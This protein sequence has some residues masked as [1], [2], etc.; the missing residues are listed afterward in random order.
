M[1]KI[2]KENSVN[3]FKFLQPDGSLSHSE[4][5]YIELFG[6]MYNQIGLQ[7]F[8]HT[9]SFDRKKFIEII[10]N[11]CKFNLYTSEN[12]RHMIENGKF[13]II[14]NA[15][16]FISEE[17][18]ILIVESTNLQFKNDAD[19]DTEEPMEREIVRI[20]NY[21]ILYPIKE[22]EYIKYLQDSFESLLGEMDKR[23]KRGKIELIKTGYNGYETDDMEINTR[24]I[25]LNK[26]YNDDIIEFDKK[27]Q[28]FINGDKSGLI[29]LHGEKGTGKTTYIRS[30]INRNIEKNYLY[31]S[32][33]LFSAF[34]SPDLVN[35]LKRL[36]NSIVIIE[37]AESLIC[38]TNGKRTASI[39]SLLNLTDG[40]LS[41]VFKLKFICTYNEDDG[42][43]D[44]A[45]LRKGRLHGSYLFKPLGIDK[46][47]KLLREL[48]SKRVAKAPMTLSD[49]Y[50]EDEIEMA[51]EDEKSKI[52]F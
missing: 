18:K 46:S 48:G 21:D 6:E 5:L 47:N 34:E 26:E 23:Q 29:L 42:K 45:L 7:S 4:Q 30:L 28:K 25:S 51:N 37:D 15:K 16:Y 39:S 40:L 19:K 49:I 31:I 52:G 17:K 3:S 9:N 32:K 33:N 38:K 36:K 8:M 35:L 2:K 43:I 1:E 12:G 13:S 41:D 10:E 11:S 20:Y 50:Y 44:D 14:E 24:P 27:M 22:K